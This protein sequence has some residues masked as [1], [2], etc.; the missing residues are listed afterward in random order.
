MS[1]GS[2]ANRSASAAVSRRT[3]GRGGGIAAP[4][5]SVATMRSQ[6][7]VPGAD[8]RSAGSHCGTGVD[9]AH[10]GGQV[11]GG[12][13]VRVA[14]QGVVAAAGFG[15]HDPGI[16]LP[17]DRAA[18]DPGAQDLLEHQRARPLRGEPRPQRGQV[19][20]R[21]G[22]HL[23]T[24]DQIRRPRHRISASGSFLPMHPFG[25]TAGAVGPD[26][27]KGH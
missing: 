23:V 12:G 3:S 5:G 10:D 20:G 6:T 21:H 17:V 8:R 26:G 11:V 22:E 15:E 1:A 14:A 9:H 18:A 24:V 2:A 25:R 27:V 13:G 7:A 4:A 19:F 16:A